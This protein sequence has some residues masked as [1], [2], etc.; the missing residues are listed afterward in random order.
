[1]EY[2]EGATLKH[3]ITG[4]PFDIETVLSL[5]IELAHALNAAHGKGIVH[6]DSKLANFFYG[7]GAR[8]DSRF[9]SAKRMARATERRG[10]PRNPAGS[11]G[12]SLQP[13]NVLPL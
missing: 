8:Q 13:R 4:K 6:R 9:G 10:I 1:M 3:R 5:G 2:L 11:H 7:S 12:A